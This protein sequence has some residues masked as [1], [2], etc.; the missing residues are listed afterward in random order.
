MDKPTRFFLYFIILTAIFMSSVLQVPVYAATFIVDNATDT[1]D[2]TL[3]DGI[4]A[5][6]SGNC[7]LRAAIQESNALA[8]ADIIT[9][10]AGTFNLALTGTGE[11][12]AATGDLDINGSLTISGAGTKLSFIDGQDLDRVF[13]VGPSAAAITVSMSNL[14]IRNGTV[15]GN[16]GLIRNVAILSLTEVSLESGQAA[17]GGGL[18]TIGNLTVN[19]SLLRDNNASADGGGFF[20]GGGITSVTN[21]TFSGN[22]ATGNG[23]GLYL[24]T[25]VTTTLDYVTIA[26]NTAVT[27]GGGGLYNAA[28]LTLNSTIISDNTVE[29]CASVGGTVTTDGSGLDSGNTCGLTM[30]V[31]LV[32]TNPA[33]GA[34]VD[35]GGETATHNLTAGS[36]AIDTANVTCP[37]VDQRNVVRPVDGDNSMT[38]ECDIGAYEWTPAIDLQVSNNHDKDCVKR[39]RDVT[40]YIGVSNIGTGDASSVVLTDT[41]PASATFISATGGCTFLAGVVTCDVGILAAGTSQNFTIVVNAPVV[42][43]LQNTVAVNAAEQD[44][45][46]ANNSAVESTRINCSACFIATA[47]YGS[48]W[49]KEVISLRLFRDQFLINNKTGRQLVLFYYRVSPV[50]AEEI[51]SSELYRLLARISL[52]PVIALSKLLTGDQ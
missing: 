22:T 12:L 35:N 13:D 52:A 46:Q 41:L 17:T 19:R 43:Y 5:D 21:S 29:N 28:S 2:V 26:F 14:V 1:V 44:N 6:S 37:G 7:S 11:E 27:N 49:T 3:G 9:L 10:P 39:G 42:D 50:L 33:L 4:C 48:A 20:Q 36:P 45:N 23:G 15:T 40:Y 25:A 38:A 30:G 16:G 34:L 24:A 18:H 31:D 32:N 8:G 51:R 47:A